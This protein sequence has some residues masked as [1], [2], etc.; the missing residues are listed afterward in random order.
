MNLNNIMV[1]KKK[2]NLRPET[3]GRTD[4]VICGK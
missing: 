2:Y 1:Q 3:K 4:E